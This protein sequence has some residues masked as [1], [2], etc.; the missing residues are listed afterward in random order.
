MESEK[1]SRFATLRPKPRASAHIQSHGLTPF[2]SIANR[3]ATNR[4]LGFESL[5]RKPMPPGQDSLSDFLGAP[6][7]RRAADH[8]GCNGNAAGAREPD[9]REDQ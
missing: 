8:Q 4:R 2:L 1:R 6:T 5:V 9:L 3:G 7:S